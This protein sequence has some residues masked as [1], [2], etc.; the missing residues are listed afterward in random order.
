MGVM[1]KNNKEVLF[2]TFKKFVATSFDIPEDLINQDSVFTTDF[3]IDSLS[4]Y[5]FVADIEQEYMVKLEIEDLMAINTV[6][7]VCELISI[8]A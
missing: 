1:T 7:K 8:K 4:L 6:G 5:S 2:K 3:G